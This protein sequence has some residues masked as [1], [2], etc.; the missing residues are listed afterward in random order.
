MSTR[1]LLKVAQ[2]GVVPDKVASK[3]VNPPQRPAEIPPNRARCNDKRCCVMLLDVAVRLCFYFA[4]LGLVPRS[5][6]G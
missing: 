3:G 1:M 4:Y 6:M 2:G 5:A